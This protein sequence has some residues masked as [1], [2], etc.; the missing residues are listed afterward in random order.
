MCVKRPRAAGCS[1]P[2]I[3]REHGAVPICSAD[4]G[5]WPAKARIHRGRPWAVSVPLVVRYGA[6]P[7][8]AWWEQG[9][10]AAT[11]SDCGRS[12]P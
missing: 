1:H 6:E 7:L 3:H 4:G 11:S 12:A 8:F 2:Q 9:K 5:H 10:M